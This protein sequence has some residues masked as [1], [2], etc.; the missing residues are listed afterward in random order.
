M[1]AMQP[2]PGGGDGLAV[3]GIGKSPAAKTP[4]TL[5]YVVPAA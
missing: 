5:V 4:G 3:G 1:A 2:D